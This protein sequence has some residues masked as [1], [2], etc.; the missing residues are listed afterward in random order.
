MTLRLPQPR[1]ISAV[2]WSTDGEVWSSSRHETGESKNTRQPNRSGACVGP[3]TASES[4]FGAASTVRRWRSAVDRLGLGAD[5][6][7]VAALRHTRQQ[8]SPADRP[9]YHVLITCLD[10]GI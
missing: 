6:R 1:A 5:R 3:R 9:E 7:P 2:I 4:T 8:G 10:P